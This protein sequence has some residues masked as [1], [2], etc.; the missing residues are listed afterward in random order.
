MVAMVWPGVPGWLGLAVAIPAAA[1]FLGT[2]AVR[3][4][5]ADVHH[6][7]MAAAMVWM[8]VMALGSAACRA[9]PGPVEGVA[10]GY[11]WLAAAPFLAMPFRTAPVRTGGALFGSLANA[12]MSVAMALLL[13]VG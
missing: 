7:V 12:A 13:T 3:R 9:T 10:A 5:P 2:A 1:W 11:F 8:A 6:A 4:R